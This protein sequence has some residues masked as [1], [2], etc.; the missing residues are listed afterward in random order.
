VPLKSR[1]STHC[2]TRC[3]SDHF[4][5]KWLAGEVSGTGKLKYANPIKRY[6]IE[7]SGDKC[8]L[9]EFNGHNPVSGKTILQIDHIDGRWDNN[10]PSNVRLICPNCHAMTPNYGFLNK[11]NGREYRYKKTLT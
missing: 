7:A 1:R 10:S 6:L 11:G 4:I 5:R 2:S 3:H 8:Q 9:C